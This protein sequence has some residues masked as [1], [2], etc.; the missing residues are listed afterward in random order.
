MGACEHDR[1]SAIAAALD[2]TACDFLSNRGVTWWIAGK[3]RF[4]KRREAR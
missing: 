3:L 4:C 1:V 2:K